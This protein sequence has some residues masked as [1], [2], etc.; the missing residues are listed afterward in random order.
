[1]AIVSESTARRLW[2][3]QEAL[4]QTV[5][6][7]KPFP[8]GQPAQSGGVVIGVARD[9]VSNLRPRNG[10]A[11]SRELIYSPL[12]PNSGIPATPIVRTKGDPDAARR[13]L[14]RVMAEVY[15]DSGG[16]LVWT[17]Q[18]NVDAF[19]YPYRA[20]AAIAG[21][22]GALALLLTVSGVFGVSSYA[23]AQRRKEFGIRIALG[24]GSLR[25]TGMVVAQNLRLGLAGA[26][27]GALAALGV[28]RMFSRAD[29]LWRA[30]GGVSMRNVDVFDV[31]G[32]AAGAAIVIAAAAAAA[33][34]PARRAVKVDPV[35]TLRCD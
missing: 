15:P 9:S 28:A 5:R 11:P 26:A 3:H 30:M 18:G 6:F 14:E 4:G 23:V 25:V 27:V 33:W 19:L 21:V 24:A 31:G 17:L 16:D 29:W 35:V 8:Y 7:A 32:Y 20:L 2:P 10:V 34:V 13:P 12:G 22:L 1:V